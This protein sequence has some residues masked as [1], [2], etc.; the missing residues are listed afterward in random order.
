MAHVQ[1]LCLA[2]HIQ[3]VE[4]HLG[5]GDAAATHRYVSAELRHTRLSHQ[6]AEGNTGEVW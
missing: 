5:C 4:V 6:H 1:E 2:D 3:R